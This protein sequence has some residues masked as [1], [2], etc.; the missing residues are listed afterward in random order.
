MGRTEIAAA[1]SKADDEAWPPDAR[2]RKTA[3]GSGQWLS[4]PRRDSS[5]GGTNRSVKSPVARE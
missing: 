1:P 5:D 2:R 3:T 4:V